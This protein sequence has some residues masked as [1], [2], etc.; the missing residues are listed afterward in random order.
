[1]DENS[2][3]E[4]TISNLKDIKVSIKIW[5]FLWLK[6]LSNLKIDDINGGKITVIGALESRGLSLMEL[7]F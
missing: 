4:L 5:L 3:T 2:K 6:E 7:L 1:M